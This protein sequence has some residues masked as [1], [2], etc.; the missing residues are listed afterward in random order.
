MSG[1]NVNVQD[2]HVFTPLHLAVNMRENP[3]RTME[4]LLQANADPHITSFPNANGEC[5]SAIDEA[6]TDE[7][8]AYL[9]EFVPNNKV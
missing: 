8:K 2:K 3:S 6:L 5:K 9:R 1:I 4:V 7:L